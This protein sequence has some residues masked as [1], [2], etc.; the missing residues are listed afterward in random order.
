MASDNKQPSREALQAEIASLREQVA[1]LEQEKKDIELMMALTAEHSDSVADELY[2]AFEATQ[3]E[4]EE[5]FTL[6]TNTVPVPIFISWLPDDVIVYANSA[7]GELIGTSSEMLVDHSIKEFYNQAIERDQILA[8]IETRKLVDNREIEGKSVEGTPFWAALFARPIT[9]NDQPCLLEAYHNLTA[10][11]QAEI[12]QVKLQEEIIQAQQQAIRD[13]STPVIP[14][15]NTS[16]GGIIIMPLVGNIDSTRAREITRS[17]LAGISRHK[18]KIVIVDITGVPLID[19]GVAA[20]LTKAIQ[21]AHLKGAKTIV[22]GISEAV[23]ETIVDLGIDWSEITTLSDL[24]N[25]LLVA[26]K[27]LGVEMRKPK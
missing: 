19:T 27:S 1:A 25:G 21:A 5:R 16:Q 12:E 26:L 23:A 14:V 7:A 3:R 11:K 24:Q 20:Y 2:S 13:L 9:F 18:A 8:E 10:Y 6:I 4:S 17:L 15:L 22:T